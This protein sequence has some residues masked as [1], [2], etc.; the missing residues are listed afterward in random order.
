M[1]LSRDDLKKIVKE[2]LVEILDEGLSGALTEHR[3]PQVSESP[4]QQRTIGMRQQRP[5]GP[6]PEVAEAIK[7]NAGGNPLMEAILADTAATTLPEMIKGDSSG[8]AGAGLEHFDGTPEEVFG[9]GS[10]R[11]A[12]LAFATPQ[13]KLLGT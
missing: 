11:W 9:D 4:K 10:S 1:K 3:R 8:I 13:K 5:T 7:R 12:D 2:C 6:S